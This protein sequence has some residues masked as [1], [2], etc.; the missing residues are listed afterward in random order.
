MTACDQ[1]LISSI[2]L[3]KSN[4]VKSPRREKLL[5]EASM[6]IDLGVSALLSIDYLSILNAGVQRL[7]HI[8]VPSSSLLFCRNLRLL[9]DLSSFPLM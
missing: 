8:D 3:S 6:G 5:S 1:T 2:S 7:L 4:C 9:Y